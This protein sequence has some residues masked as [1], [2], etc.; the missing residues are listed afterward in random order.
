MHTS[1]LDNS[2]NRM[3]RSGSHKQF[4]VYLTYIWEKKHGDGTTKTAVYF[5][6]AIV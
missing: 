6:A 4:Y 1:V 2:V 3:Q 5:Q